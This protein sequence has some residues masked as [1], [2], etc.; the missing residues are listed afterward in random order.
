MSLVEVVGRLGK[1]V[2]KFHGHGFIYISYH[3][4]NKHQPSLLPPF[5]LISSRYTKELQN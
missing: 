5:V 3:T 4:L 1:V 2:R